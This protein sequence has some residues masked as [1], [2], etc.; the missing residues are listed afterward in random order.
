MIIRAD[1][2]NSEKVPEIGD[3]FKIIKVEKISAFW[4]I[5]LEKI[6]VK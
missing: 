5:E 6:N 1:T 2:N 4:I 3:K